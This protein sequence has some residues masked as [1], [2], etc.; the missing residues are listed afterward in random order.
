MLRLILQEVKQPDTS[1]YNMYHALN[2]QIIFYI[3]LP[4]TDR[5]DLSIKLWSV[6]LIQVNHVHTQ[7]SHFPIPSPSVTWQPW[8]REAC[9]Y[10]RSVYVIPKSRTVRLMAWIRAP[11][12]VAICAS[13]VLGTAT[14]SSG[15]CINLLLQRRLRVRG[16]ED[17]SLTGVQL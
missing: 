11:F 17:G 4:K 6:I 15:S 9:C 16:L 7:Y 14:T 12:E 13:F 5:S 3:C 2:A 1:T 8:M 10:A